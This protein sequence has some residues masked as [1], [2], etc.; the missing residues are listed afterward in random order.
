MKKLFF[1]VFALIF[2]AVLTLTFNACV[3]KDFDQ[4]PI[5]NGTNPEGI[6]ANTTIAQLKALHDGFDITDITDDVIIE[7]VV[8][9]NDEAGNFYKEIYVQDATGGIKIGLDFTE[10][11]NDYQEGRKLFIKCQNLKIDEFSGI[12]SLGPAVGDNG[13]LVRM[14]KVIADEHIFPGELN[15]FVTPNVVTINEIDGDVLGTL[16]TLENVQFIDG[17]LGGTYAD[18]D[19]QT[20]LNR[21][22]M[23]CNGNT[24]IM[25]NSG[26]ASFAGVSLPTGNGSVTGIANQF[27]DDKQMF[28]SDTDDVNMTAERCDGSSG[29]GT[30]NEVRMDIAD[31]RALY[32]GTDTDIPA[33]TKIIGTVISDRIEGNTVSQNVV[34][35]DATGGITVRFTADHFLN[36]NDEV[37]V[38]VSGEQLSEFNGLLQV[39]FIP[40]GNAS[41]IGTGSV[42]PLT[43]TIDDI[44]ANFESMEST[45]VRIEGATLTGGNTYSGGLTLNDGTASI[46]LWT[47]FSAAFAD[48]LAPTNGEDVSLVAIVSEYNAP[49]LGI[50]NLNDVSAEGG[51]GGGDCGLDENFASGSGQNNT[52][53]N[54][55]G[56]SNMPMEGNDPWVFGE[57]G[58]DVFAK[59]QGYQANGPDVETWLITPSFDIST[60][61][62]LTFNTI[63]GYPVSGHE[64]LEVLI[65]QN[66]DGTNVG[67]ATWT[68]LSANIASES[69]VP[70]GNFSDKVPS[71]EIALPT[72]GTAH[73]AFV[74]TGDNSTNTSTMEVD[75]VRVCEP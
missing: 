11:Y 39:D 70:S 53:L 48:A 50:R 56:W 9:T 18:A 30:G 44:L 13:L 31:L 1:P 29:G 10:I 37:E 33:E 51:G 55:A 14:P 49:Q 45:L 58:G 12:Y 41:V 26:F 47:Q 46:D 69:D 40:N 36:M 66:F 42:S 68:P 8:T 60:A 22:L 21:N 6:V 75:D 35:Q 23:D 73:I 17:E 16:V 19:N 25:R 67:A 59:I 15:H 28:I 57:F 4:P 27:F 63:I 74:Y 24:I 65:S 7:A 43:T 32:T 34:I 61:Q 54:L 20:T 2:T 62:V 71:G 52:T 5:N 72:G 38:V 3:D 64:A